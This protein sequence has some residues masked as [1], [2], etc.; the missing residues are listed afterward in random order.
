MMNDEPEYEVFVE[1]WQI[2]AMRDGAVFKTRYL[3][4]DW[5][6]MGSYGD[7]AKGLIYCPITDPDRHINPRRVK[8]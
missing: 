5:V 7:P 6:P 2:T 4:E 1:V 8:K 3:H